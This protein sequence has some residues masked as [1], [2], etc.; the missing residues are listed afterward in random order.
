M[1][2]LECFIAAAIGDEKSALDTCTRC[3]REHLA[4]C[5]VNEVYRA[6]TGMPIEEV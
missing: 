6:V 5:V 1:E 3:G 4:E 2:N